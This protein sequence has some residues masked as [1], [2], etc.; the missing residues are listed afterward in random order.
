[1]TSYQR[2][3][4]VILLVSAVIGSIGSEYPRQ[5]YLQ[6]FPTVI[7]LAILPSVARRIPLTNAAFTCIVGFMLLHV[8]GARY[9]YSYV[10][11]DDWSQRLWGFSLTQQFGFRRNHF[12]RFV[13]F[14]FGVLA[15]RPVWEILTRR[16]KVPPRFAY[17]AAFEFVLAFSLLYELFEW[18]LTIALSPQ[19]AGAYNGEQGD[20]WDAHRDMS[21]AVMGVLM[22]LVVWRI[23]SRNRTQ[24]AA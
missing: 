24:T 5:M 10:P 1:M 16:F 20:I 15:A 17:Y 19:D 12:D 3:L 9:I 23:T 2:A 6:H 8:V 13:H 7:A 4:W 21:F 14:A 11:Y 18:G 22:S